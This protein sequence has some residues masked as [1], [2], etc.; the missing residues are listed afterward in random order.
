MAAGQRLAVA[1]QADAERARQAGRSLARQLG[2]G[3]ADA[4]RVALTVSELAT[5]LA[6]YARG[7]EIVLSAVDGPRGRGLQVESHD[8]GPGISDLSRALED[9]Y[10]TGGGLG[11]GL[12]AARRLVDEFEIL[13]GP[14]GTRIVARTWPSDR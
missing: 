4:E 9:N 5:N 13:S 12:P 14:E 1:S 8:A 2:F 6:R 7:G 3:P 10:S 11:C